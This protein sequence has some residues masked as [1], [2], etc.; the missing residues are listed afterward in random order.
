MTVVK[1]IA[2][3]MRM[4]IMIFMVV[5]MLMMIMVEVMV[6]IRMMMVDGRDCSVCV[7]LGECSELA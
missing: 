6:M 3:E 2:S 5:M 7:V 1:K 4:A